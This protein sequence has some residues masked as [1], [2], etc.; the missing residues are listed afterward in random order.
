[1][2]ARLWKGAPGCK[3]SAESR[4]VLCSRIYNQTMC[5]K[6][7][8]FFFIYLHKIL[9][10][11]RGCVVCM[12]CLKEEFSSCVL[13]EYYSFIAYIYI[14]FSSSEQFRRLKNCTESRQITILN[15]KLRFIFLDIFIH[16]VAGWLSYNWNI[17]FRISFLFH[18]TYILVT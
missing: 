8:D 9:S 5:M 3:P 6:S 10:T 18:G 7:E 14:S 4:Y 13:L 11:L 17:K 16:N 1:M 2:L 15:N 12:Q